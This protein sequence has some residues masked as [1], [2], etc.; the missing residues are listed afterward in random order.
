MAFTPPLSPLVFLAFLGTAA[1]LFLAGA[2]VVVLLLRRRFELARK[3]LWG[4]LLWAG[5]YIVVLLGFSFLSREKTLAAGEW[6][7]FCEVDCHLAYSLVDVTT[8]KTLGEPPNQ[9]TAQGTFYVVNVK[10]WFDE[11]TIS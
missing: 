3:V 8:S 10:M 5:L 4:G 9:V 1:A 2:A 11:K 7:Y 6:K